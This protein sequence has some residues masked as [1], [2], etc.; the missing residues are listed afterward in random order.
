LL[1]IVPVLSRPDDPMI[2]PERVDMA[3]MVEVFHHVSNKLTFLENTRRRVEPGA[4]LV[5]IE[6]DVN[7]EGGNP[8]GCYSD[9][10]STRRLVEQAGF[11]VVELRTKKIEDLVFFVLIAKAL[12]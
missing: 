10:G 7:Q 3:I 6:P 1:N 11:R 2:P 9:P 12:V 4:L 5:I 8:N